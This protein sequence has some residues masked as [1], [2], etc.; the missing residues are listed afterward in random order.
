M[1]RTRGRELF[2]ESS[3]GFGRS[4]PDVCE[5]VLVFGSVYTWPIGGRCPVEMDGFGRGCWLIAIARQGCPDDP[6]NKSGEPMSSIKLA[7]Q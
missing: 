3:H 1:D 7:V 6:G 4:S 5:A 2:W